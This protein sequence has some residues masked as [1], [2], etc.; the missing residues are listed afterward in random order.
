MWRR[1]G[2]NHYISRALVIDDTRPMY[3]SD[4][5]PATV[6]FEPDGNKIRTKPGTSLLEAAVKAGNRIRSECGGNGKCGK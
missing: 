5:D 3:A 2:V 1:P 6:V 4:D